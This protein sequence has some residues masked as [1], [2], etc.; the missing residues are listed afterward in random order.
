MHAGRVLAGLLQAHRGQ[1]GLVILG[2]PRG[3]VP[4]AAEVARALLGDLDVY[5][6]RKLGV[7]GREELAMGAVASGGVRV[8]NDDIVRAL[9]VSPEVVAAVTAA[10]ERDLARH[11]QAYRRDRSPVPVEGRPV[12]VVDDGMATGSTMRAAVAALRRLKPASVAVAVPTSPAETLR[13]LATEADEVVCASVPEPFV[14]VGHSYDDF[15]PTTD[16]EVRSLLSAG[17]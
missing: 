11:E 6:V 10:A 9:G 5:V 17:S 2:L 3:G 16:D 8:L 14:A 13:L 7:P 15:R 1:P 12:I 4:V